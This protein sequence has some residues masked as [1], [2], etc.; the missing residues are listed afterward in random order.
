MKRNCAQAI[1]LSLCLLSLVSGCVGQV[2]TGTP[3]F[4]SFGGGS[5]DTIN[6]GNG[7]VHF[8]IPILIKAGR[9]RSFTYK[10]SYD[11]SIWYPA[12]VSGNQVWTPIANWGWR[13]QTEVAT[14]YLTYT[15]WTTTCF[16]PD[17]G[18]ITSV[19]YTWTGYHD[20]FGSNHKFGLLPASSDGACN[21]ATDITKIAV[22][23][24][25]YTLYASAD[26]AY[27]TDPAGT[28]IHPPINQTGGTATSTDANGNQI[29]A[30]G[31]GQFFDTLSGTVPV[32]TVGGA[33]SQSNPLTFTYLSP[34]GT[35]AV[36]TMKYSNKT[37][38]TFFQCTGSSGVGDYPAALNVPLVAEIDL[39]DIS[40]NPTAKY[41][42]TYEDSHDNNYPGSVTGRIATVT[43]PTGGKI[44]YLYSGGTSGINCEDGT[45]ATFNR[46]L[47]DGTKDDGTWTYTRTGSGNAWATVVQ[48][49]L[50]NQ[51][52]I[53]FQKDSST[54]ATNDFFETQRLEYD[55]GTLLRTI[56]TCYNGTG[57]TTPSTC[58]TTAVV[59]PIN[60]R[61]V[62]T[63]LPDS[64]GL[65]S[66]VDS[67]HNALGQRSELDV[68]DYGPAA[69]GPILRK[70]VLTYA[71]FGFASRRSI[72]SVRDANNTIKASTT[73]Y[74]DQTAVSAPTGT[75]P[76][77]ISVT[78]GR[79]NMTEIATLANGSVTLYRKFT[80]YDTGML[81]TSTD[82]S[83]SATTDGALTT[84]NY[85]NTGSPSPSCGNSFVTSVSEPLSLSRS[86]TWD[87]K[88]GVMISST[89]ENSRNSSVAYNSAYFW[90][91]A[92]SSDQLTNV[93]NF[94]Y[95]GDQRCRKLPPCQ[96][97]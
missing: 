59:T 77:H 32:L 36:Y 17:F 84:Y 50:G 53:S 72:L 34:A 6:L 79:G 76:Q 70:T 13:G 48:D 64:S 42:F 88:G 43:L 60:R 27:V 12:T 46:V 81:K 65:Q 8:E 24:S 26:T 67:F 33:G 63:Y 11:S 1:G 75:T 7:N 29:T 19:H 94:S 86:M 35:N 52:A 9:G 97:Q 78:G 3:K 31:S 83:I 49:P 18:H 61:T 14:G 21:E 91:P 92:S 2:S 10:L 44:S 20:S 71:N 96:Q 38:R 16:D 28:I 58:P 87:C 5:F 45:A 57:V 40:V 73:F 62:F 51:S 4:A 25:G 47:T 55:S 74:Y 80:Y 23:G 69:V 37:V 22:D 39:P 41:T 54:N 82:V 90:R 30:N 95:T 93:T 15:T 66:E 85:N 56:V 68:Y 89:D